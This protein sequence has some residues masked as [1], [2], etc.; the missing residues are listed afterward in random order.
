MTGG[1]ST[2][3]GVC[4]IIWMPL[5]PK[6]A[7]DL[8]R[9]CEEWRRDN[10]TEEERELAASLGERYDTPQRLSTNDPVL[11]VVLGLRRNEQDCRSCSPNYPLLC[12][13]R[14]RERNSTT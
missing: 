12:T 1:E 13:I 2:L 10:M 14:K 8:E 3:H 4:V 11:M 7:D 9:R 5:N 6:A